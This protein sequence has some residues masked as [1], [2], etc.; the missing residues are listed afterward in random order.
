MWALGNHEFLQIT[1]CYWANSLVRGSG[2]ISVIASSGPPGQ[3]RQQRGVRG[4]R[5]IHT[6]MTWIRCSIIRWGK[7]ELWW[8][9]GYKMQPGG[10]RI[11]GRKWEGISRQTSESAGGQHKGSK[12]PWRRT[13][14]RLSKAGGGI[15]G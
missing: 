7:D 14:G 5:G 9:H 15:I 12:Q 4:S 11:R 13:G 8:Y 6:S 3:L 10:W 1:R 2:G